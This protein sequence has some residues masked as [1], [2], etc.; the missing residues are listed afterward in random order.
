MKF[1]LDAPNSYDALRHGLFTLFQNFSLWNYNLYNM[2]CVPSS[3]F[4][5]NAFPI[6]MNKGS[7][8]SKRYVQHHLGLLLTVNLQQKERICQCNTREINLEVHT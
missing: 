3:C 7:V 4:S 2:N 6:S 1:L 8:A 5:I